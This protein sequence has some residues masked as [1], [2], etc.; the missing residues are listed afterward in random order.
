MTDI[1]LFGLFMLGFVLG[2]GFIALI[3]IKFTCKHDY[4]TR[5]HKVDKLYAD[6]MIKK[7]YWIYTQTCKHCGK[8]KSKTIGLKD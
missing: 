3:F 4:E 7:T 1:Q 5:I 6:G 8:I 2:V